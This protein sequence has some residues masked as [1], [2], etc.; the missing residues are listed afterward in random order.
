MM[1]VLL[2]GEA[3]SAEQF[4]AFVTVL[5]A[6]SAKLNVRA[7]S[8]PM[9]MRAASASGQTLLARVAF[10]VIDITA[11]PVAEPRACIFLWQATIQDRNTS[12]CHFR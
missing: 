4:G 2:G 6:L 12:F 1:D 8:I 5:Q 10:L 11:T 9:V 3:V 7:E